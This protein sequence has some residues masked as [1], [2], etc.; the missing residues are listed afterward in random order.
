MWLHPAVPTI[1]KF[2][3]IGARTQRGAPLRLALRRCSII[4]RSRSSWVQAPFLPIPASVLTVYLYHARR[5]LSMIS[6]RENGPIPRFRAGPS[7]SDPRFSRPREGKRPIPAIS[8]FS[9]RRSR[10]RRRA[11]PNPGRP[12]KS[13]APRRCSPSARPACRRRGSS[14]PPAARSS[15]SAPR[16]DGG[17]S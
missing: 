1:R 4:R 12:C 13:A 7:G 17:G 11:S 2:F 14:A 5:P 15:A 6:R 9:S 10:S 16:P 8:L 3:K